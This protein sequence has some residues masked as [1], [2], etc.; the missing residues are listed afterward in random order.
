MTGGE[1]RRLVA[2]DG[3]ALSYWLTVSGTEP[4]RALLLVHGAASNHT[5]WSELVEN[6]DLT[7]SW[8]VIQPDVRGNGE[9]LTRRGLDMATWCR[10]LAEI[11]ETEDYSEVVVVGHSLGAQMAIHFARRF[12]RSVVG[13]VLIDP[14][15]PEALRGKLRFLT[16]NV[17]LV[18]VCAA[19][20]GGLNRLGLRRRRI[21]NRDIRALD[22]ETR[23]A[24]AEEGATSQAI[25]KR[26]GA[27]GL[28]LRH[29]PTANFLRQLLATVSPLPA[30]D[31]IGTPTLV[32]LSRGITFA[33]FELNRREL[34]RIP[35]G[36][37][38]TLDAHHWPLTETPDETRRAIEGWID[39][40]FDD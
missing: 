25:A 21:P 15:V 10:D 31:E 39:R 18:R 19:I 17:W 20:I 36:E 35:H 3:V 5:R 24:L 14:V 37:L 28:I 22:E 7:D 2:A 6:T 32:L 4:R 27:L 8:D 29:M 9:S 12:P 38:A 33:D 16:K 1:P 13:L 11:L 26:Y 30:L 23:A 40:H 34:S